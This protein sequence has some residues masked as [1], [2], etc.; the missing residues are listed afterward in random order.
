MKE[1]S[2]HSKSGNSKLKLFRIDT[3]IPCYVILIGIAS[4]ISCKS[5]TEGIASDPDVYY[6]CSMDPQV[7]EAKPGKCPICNMQLTSARKSVKENESELQLSPQQIQLG[8]IRVDTIRNGSISNEFTLTGVLNFNQLNSAAISARISGRVDKLYFKNT[9]EY[10]RKGAKLYDLYSEELNN[11]KQEYILA[12]QK[13][14]AIGNSM[15]DYDALILSAKNKLLLWGMSEQQVK[16]LGENDQADNLTSFYSNSSGYITEL[17]IKE[18][19]YLKEGANILRLADLSTLWAEAQL[20]ATQIPQVN[21]EA[22]AVV[23]IP[24]IPGKE[25]QGKIEF[26]NPE[27]NP[28]TRINL[29]RITVPNKEGLLK[30]GMPVYVI[31]KNPKFKTLSLPSDAVLRT[32]SMASVWIQTGANRF[33]SKMVETGTETDGMIEIK[34]GLHEGDAVVVNG[35]YLLQSEYIFRKGTNP[36]QGHD[37]S[38]MKM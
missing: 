26:V 29:L 4:F 5:K 13:R 30:P 12:T 11:A 23:K 24:D 8:N 2:R 38:N 1:N 16:A 19:D 33:T 21:P 25:I 7:I 18:G 17:N 22:K 9:G 20:Y 35:A 28:A 27:I 10:V 31:L 34:S 36:M 32:G 15:I 6:T 37:M 14:M 3:A